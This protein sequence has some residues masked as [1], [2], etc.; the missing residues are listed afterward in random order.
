MEA[1]MIAPE[2]I[3]PTLECAQCEEHPNRPCPACAARRRRAVRLV[4][5]LGLNTHEA[6]RRMRLPVGRVERLLEEE[7]DRRS[8]AAFRVS[9]VSNAPLRKR[10]RQRQLFDPTLTFS[11][12]AQRLG[13]SP[14]Q[15]ERWLGLAPTAPK[16]DRRGHTYPPRILSTISVE[17][18]GRLAR[19]MGYAPNDFDGCWYGD[20]VERASISGGSTM[21]APTVSARY[22]S[23]RGWHDIVVARDAVGGWQVLDI[24]GTEAALVE[25]LTGHDDRLDQADALARDY[26]AQQQAHHDGRRPD[27][28]PRRAALRRPSRRS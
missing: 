18:A 27:P 4:E 13:T 8:L 16:T 19:A 14:I 1:V 20:G 6:A 28:L 26:A 10:F 5:S 11:A 3:D 2:V 9:H 12:L 17:N 7:A 24:V 25:S 21:A 22:R 15:V 23:T